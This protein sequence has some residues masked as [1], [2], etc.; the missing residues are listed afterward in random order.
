MK[1]NKIAVRVSCVMLV[2]AFIVASA[3]ALALFPVRSS[4]AVASAEEIS[5]VS[6]A[7]DAVSSADSGFS[8]P[9]ILGS[10][11]GINMV[12]PLCSPYVTVP[13][14]VTVTQTKD[15]SGFPIA[16]FTLSS[17]TSD[18]FLIIEIP[19]SVLTV[20]TSYFLSVSNS[21]S[22][23]FGISKCSGDDTFSYSSV[24][25]VYSHNWVINTPSEF[26]SNVIVRFSF[27][28]DNSTVGL[29]FVQLI[30]GTYSD[31]NGYCDN[32]Y[33]FG[34][35]AGQTYGYNQGQ[36]EGYNQ[37]KTDGYNEGYQAGQTDGYNQG[38]TDGYNEGYQAGQTDGYN[39][40]QSEGYQQG[41]DDGVSDGFARVNDL[42]LATAFEVSWSS[43][44]NTIYIHNDP[45]SHFVNEMLSPRQVYF[46]YSCMVYDGENGEI[47]PSDCVTPSSGE[48]PDVMNSK[49]KITFNGYYEMA[50]WLKDNPTDYLCNYLLTGENVPSVYVFNDLSNIDYY[51]SGA[52]TA[53][54]NGY[55][56][57]YN[58]GYSTGQSVGFN[59][60]YAAGENAGAAVG[61]N[62]SFINLIGAVFDAPISAFRGLLN[63]EI[64]GVN[65]SGFVTG[66]L[67]LCVVF[68]FLKLVMR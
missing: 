52:L 42:F 48:V 19:Y 61:A 58:K 44:T 40:G 56:T 4:S 9:N 53:Y 8:S 57:G 67:S 37:G 62:Y 1:Y 3:F 36:S 13:D 39:Q 46:P 64:L 28:S 51:L 66:M 41:Y 26:T 10:T 43:T 32:G 63:F 30:E 55:S 65:M 49:Y 68:L 23:S 33:N 18:Y 2:I 11:I 17:G 16:N 54:D 5:A 15:T 38:K 45:D 59:N 47:V 12:N 35:D 34:F 31:Y 29:Y 25:G 20:S 14:G 6:A 21:T 24:S 7:D 60:G 22:T 50:Q 27:P